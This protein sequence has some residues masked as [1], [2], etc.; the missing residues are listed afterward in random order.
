M[1]NIQR[2]E[3]VSGK[4]YALSGLSNDDYHA[5]KECLSTSGMKMLM[6]SPAH[7]KYSDRKETPD[8]TKGTA[9]HMILLEPEKFFQ[10]YAVYDG[11]KRG[12]QY[13]EFLAANPQKTILKTQVMDELSAMRDAVFAYPHFNLER[14][15]RVGKKEH[16]VF[17]ED[18]QTGVKL[19]AR[20]DCI[21]D[22]VIF[23]VKKTADA[24]PSKFV[25]RCVD[26]R[27]DMQ[28][29][30]YK[31]GY[32]NF[33]GRDVIFI[34]LAIEDTAPYGVW[35]HESSVDMEARGEQDVRHAINTYAKCVKE[36]NWPLYDKPKSVIEWPDWMCVK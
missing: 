18:E 19:K 4:S 28:A 16:S 21:I 2:E 26:L 10:T 12:P 34:F 33:L 25:K 3:G 1:S 13:T 14:L 5:D 15:L 36:N 23:D 20:A 22:N 27:Y 31:E 7:F 9:L 30:N 35:L 24:R 32:R 17:W 8:M 11:E 29:A 6:Q